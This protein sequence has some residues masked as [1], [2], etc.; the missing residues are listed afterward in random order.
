MK[1]LSAVAFLLTVSFN[2]FADC[3]R[4]QAMIN[5]L[6]SIPQDVQNLHSNS[7]TVT[8]NSGKIKFVMT[9]DRINQ[10]FVS[11]VIVDENSCKVEFMGSSSVDPYTVDQTEF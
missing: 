6:R 2:V 7:G 9:Y 10:K 4:G 5:A 11:E 1:T 3:P 8:N